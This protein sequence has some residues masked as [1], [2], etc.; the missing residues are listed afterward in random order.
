MGIERHIYPTA[1]EAARD[2]ATHILRHLGAALRDRSFATLAISG[3][4]SPKPM[5]ETFAATPFD[6]PRVHVYWVDERIVPPDDPQS[7][8]GLARRLFLERVGLPEANIHR[9]YG[10]LPPAEAVAR[11]AADLRR[12]FGMEA[13]GL[14]EFDVIH[15][16]MGADAHTASLFP[17]DP[18][19]SDRTNLCS[20]V[21]V[22]KMKSWRVTLLPGVLLNACHVVLFAP[23]ADKAETLDAVL[24][25]PEDV[26]ARP[27]QLLTHHARSLSLFTDE[28]AA[29][30]L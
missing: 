9:V 27:A 28:A 12:E 2:A 14:P 15:C 6:W 30:K 5:F 8:Y 21:W 26:A 13:G 22:E 1:A 24:N 20:A 4:S 23:G 7:N 19:I 11:Y 18:L 17:G 25:G 10:E 3:G 16:G 29:E